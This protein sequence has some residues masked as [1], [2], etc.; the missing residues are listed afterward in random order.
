LQGLFTA[1]LLIHILK[2]LL[3]KSIFNIMLLSGALFSA[4]AVPVIKGVYTASNNVLV[5]YLKSSVKNLEETD[6]T[7]TVWKINGAVPLALNRYVIPANRADHFLYLTVPTLEE[8]KEYKISTPYGDTTITFS[9][10]KIFCESIKTNQVAYSALSKSNF[11]NFSI[12]LGNGGGRDIKGEPPAFEVFEQ[13]T[14]KIVASGTLKK[15]G[16]NVSSGDTVYRID[17]ASVPEGGPYKIAVKGYG[18]SY[19]FGVGGAF[20]KRLAYIMFR[21]QYY[22]R[23]GCPIVKPYGL[24]IRKTACHTKVYKVNGKITEANNPVSGSEESFACYGGYHDAGDADRRVYHMANPIINLMLYETFPDLFTDNQFNIP[25][26]FD[27]TYNIV[28]KGNGIPDIIDEAAWGTLLWEYLQNDDG[29]ILYGTETTGYPSPFDAPLDQ[30]ALLYGT[31]KADDRAAATG[32]GLFMHLAR[33]LKPFDEARSKKLATRAEK[34][35]S[36]IGTRIKD[37]EKLY[38]NIQKYLYDG[39]ETAHAQVKALKSTV[40]SYDKN[41]FECHGYMLNDANFDNPGYIM[42]Y[43]LEKQ[44]PTDPEVVAYFKA[45]IKKAADGNLAELDKYSYPVANNPT[46]TKWGHN[47]MQPQ[48]AGAPLLNWKL[49]GE[50]KYF[51][52]AA[53]MI[54]YALGQNPMGISFVTGLGFHQVVNPHDRESSYSAKKLRL[55]PKPG[56]TVFGPGIHQ[57]YSTDGELLTFPDKKLLPVERLFGDNIEAISMTEFTVF[58]TMHYYGIYTVLAGGGTWDESVDPFTPPTST[59]PRSNIAD[60][61]LCNTIRSTPGAITITLATPGRIRASF[62]RVDG[63]LAGEFTSG[64][65]SAGNHTITLPLEKTTISATSGSVLLCQ[66]V[67]EDG[68]VQVARV[69]IVKQ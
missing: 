36:F 58:Q 49:T 55:G 32:A 17:L 67:F 1:Q 20:S 15:I 57:V 45:A 33:I 9:D 3:V 23:C 2:E 10:R 48:Y 61:K 62:F 31:V 6:T 52:A 39:D 13:F 59:Q 5:V 34:A 37:P 14:G 43:I 7:L 25:D 69:M 54:N 56:I 47:V 50:Q 44:R 4:T 42:S 28:G 38:Y 64:K 40:D 66:I 46:G 18:C 65:L 22:Q 21:G 35:Y 30:D 60:R 12:W 41:L 29:S 19:P 11:A 26:K 53:A 16:A 24:D 63:R 8:G 27:S 51:D 68:S